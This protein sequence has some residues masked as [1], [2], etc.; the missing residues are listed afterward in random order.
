MNHHHLGSFTNDNL[1]ICKVSTKELKRLS[2][3]GDITNILNV[4]YEYF[5][6]NEY[7]VIQKFYLEYYLAVRYVKKDAANLWPT[8]KSLEEWEPLKSMKMDTCVK[9]CKHYLM[10]DNVS[11]VTFEEGKPVFPSLMHQSHK[12]RN[13]AIS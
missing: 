10:H 9:L 3:K 12:L 5:E 2:S 8:F 1:G 4:Y 6:A 7:F 13:H 11:N